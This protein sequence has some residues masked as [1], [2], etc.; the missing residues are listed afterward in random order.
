MAKKHLSSISQANMYFF[1]IRKIFWPDKKYF[2]QADGRGIN[3][4]HYFLPVPQSEVL[5]SKC[6]PN[7]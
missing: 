5:N 7:R 2:V 3:P 1:G 4:E 6:L